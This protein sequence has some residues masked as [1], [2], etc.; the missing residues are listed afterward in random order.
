MLPRW[1]RDCEAFEDVEGAKVYTPIGPWKSSPDPQ[2]AAKWLFTGTLMRENLIEFAHALVPVLLKE[3]PEQYTREQIM[4]WVN[5]AEDELETLSVRLHV[6]YHYAWAVKRHDYVDPPWHEPNEPSELGHPRYIYIDPDEDEEEDE[7]DEEPEDDA[8]HPGEEKDEQAVAR[9]PKRF[10][11]A[12]SSPVRRYVTLGAN[13]LP[14]SDLDDEKGTSSDEDSDC[15]EDR[16][17][18]SPRRRLS[19]PDLCV[20]YGSPAI[21]LSTPGSSIA[22]STPALSSDVHE[23]W[24]VNPYPHLKFVPTADWRPD[25]EA[26]DRARLDELH[27]GWGGGGDD[28]RSRKRKVTPLARPDGRAL[29]APPQP[30]EMGVRLGQ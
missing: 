10:R 30:S 8:L 22:P 6:R 5:N 13:E 1:L 2:E 17:R 19:P 15:A 12:S 18:H 24:Y 23:H 14:E 21:P 3:S 25:P 20:E 29:F 4:E 9:S 16:R 7:E 11:S 28:G 27:A 26:I